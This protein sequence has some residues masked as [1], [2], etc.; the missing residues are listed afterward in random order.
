M[1]ADALV[2]V[3]KY[4][5]SRLQV[6]EAGLTDG[7]DLADLN[8]TAALCLAIKA[9]ADIGNDLEQLHLH[10]LACLTE[11]LLVSPWINSP[12]ITKTWMIARSELL[13]QQIP[14]A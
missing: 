7:N 8:A 1:D 4:A 2:G 13:Q 12:G 10:R 6:N 9:M 5:L 14:H 3:F 11:D